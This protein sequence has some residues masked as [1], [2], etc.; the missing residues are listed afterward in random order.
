[1]I[2][3]YLKIAWR[4]LWKHKLFSLI[5][6]LG[7]GIAIP[8]ALIAIIQLQA[9]FEYDNFHEDRDQL[10]RII[11]DVKHANGS[12][13]AYA[14][15]PYLLADKL[16]ANNPFADQSTK[17]FREFGWVL[18]NGIKTSDVNII[19][20]E[21]SFYEIFHFPLLRGNYPTEPQTLVL[22]EEMASWY[23]GDSDPVGKSL[24]HANYGELRVTGVLKHFKPKTQFRADA[25]IAMSGIDRMHPEINQATTASELET[26]TFLKLPNG[27]RPEQLT[28]SLQVASDQW[29]SE[30]LSSTGD[31]FGFRVQEF[32]DISPAVEK[33]RYNPYIEDMQDIYFNFSIPMMI[34][35]LAAFNYINLSLARS[36]ARSR[37]VGVRKAMGAFKKQLV[38]QF[39]IEAV[40]VSFLALAIGLVLVYMIKSGI[41]VR[42]INWEVDSL[43]TV[44]IFFTVFTILLGL[45]AG[46]VPSIL[47]SGVQ[48]VS[49]LK[50][51]FGPGT[52]GKLGL[53]RVLNILQFT[54]TLAFVFQIGHLYS[55]FKYMAT[56]NDN[57]NRK[58]IYD[59]SL[60]SGRDAK[61]HSELTQLK[62]VRGV[63]YTSQVFGNMPASHS[64]KKQADDDQVLS[65]YYACDQAFLDMMKLDFVSGENLPISFSEQSTPLV[66]VNRKAI[67]RLHFERPDE[68]IGQQIFLGEEQVH[69]V[70][71]VENFCHFNYQF[72]IEPIVFQYNPNLFRVASIQIDES[73]DLEKSEN[74]IAA[75]WKKVYPY[76]EAAG[77]WLAQDLFERYYP[78][79]DLKIMGVACLVIFIIAIMGLVGIITYNSEKRVK[80]IGIR[81]VLGANIAEIIRLVSREYVSLLL[82]ATAIAI[83]IGI[84]AGVLM[85]SL[86]TFN[87]GI[88]YGLM[89]T[90]TAIIS[91]LALS[92]ILGFTYKSSSNDPV[93]ALKAE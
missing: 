65:H 31:Q 77:S 30:Y 15:T 68:A 76:E 58:G 93:V 40:L 78:A 84:A 18:D 9:S 21:P 62:E 55:Q 73:A 14:S 64:I 54:V 50:G 79:E 92:L 67:E 42:W 87:D 5:N 60:R 7:L 11:T 35:L 52:F 36:T 59:L 29:T 90:C 44:L 1:M 28:K 86:F 61:L 4:S 47:M 12:K 51:N 13:E 27:V 17:V 26:H 74:E 80:E 75:R 81:K 34:L 53:R 2:V 71:V 72:D 57:F 63:G 46:A 33:L 22:T 38:F 66:V 43:A 82:V 91:G 41:H 20:T 49:V 88:N 16:K 6:I 70:G 23:F 89:A 69:I 10:V 8:F 56:E 48:P 45:G 24:H 37:E 85:T 3:N 19:F 39:L 32:A 83:P 25:F